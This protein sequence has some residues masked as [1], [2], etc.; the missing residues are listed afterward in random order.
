M[1]NHSKAPADNAG[2]VLDAAGRNLRQAQQRL[3]TLLEAARLAARERARRV[4]PHTARS[5]AR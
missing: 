4:T 2:R 5:T 3:A 1:G